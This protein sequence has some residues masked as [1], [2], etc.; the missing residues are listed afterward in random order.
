MKKI[1]IACVVY[2]GL[3][4]SLYDMEASP[5]KIIDREITNIERAF[6]A[7]NALTDQLVCAV[8]QAIKDGKDLD[9]T[10]AYSQ[11]ITA[12]A[13][14][15]ADKKI[16]KL[17]EDWQEP[18]RKYYAEVRQRF[19]GEKFEDPQGLLVACKKFRRAVDREIENILIEFILTE[20][21]DDN[22][23]EHA[24]HNDAQIIDEEHK[25]DELV[26]LIRDFESLEPQFPEA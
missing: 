7:L 11:K 20:E 19:L 5:E 3:T 6:K 8:K 10:I 23:D 26:G 22:A 4:V 9:K 2:V 17:R 16:K 25:D 24:G 12:N 14:Q 13:C 15:K 18:I 1:I 21:E